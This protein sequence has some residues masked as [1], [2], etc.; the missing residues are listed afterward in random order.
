MSL[1][2][3]TTGEASVTGP[4][5]HDGRL[6]LSLFANLFYNAVRYGIVWIG[7]Q[8]P[9]NWRDQGFNRYPLMRTT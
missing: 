1:Q 7:F 3:P 6:L 4:V 5:D 8:G 9:R 2:Q